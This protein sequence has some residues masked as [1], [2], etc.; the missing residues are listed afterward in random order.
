[1]LDHKPIVWKADERSA[2]WW[3]LIVWYPVRDIRTGTVVQQQFGFALLWLYWLVHSLAAVKF[4]LNR[5]CCPG[6][7]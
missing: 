1:M 3:Y 5:E 2:G 4:V 7:S 6:S